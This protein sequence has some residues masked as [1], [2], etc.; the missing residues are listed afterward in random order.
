M[1]FPSGSVIRT[2][3]YTLLVKENGSL[4]C[5]R[6]GERTWRSNG[7]TNAT[8]PSWKN[9]DVFL[10]EQEPEWWQVDIS[11]PKDW[12]LPAKQAADEAV[13]RGE[14]CGHIYSARHKD[15][16]DQIVNPLVAFYRLM[17]AADEFPATYKYGT[18]GSPYSKTA[19]QLFREVE[20][21]PRKWVE[22]AYA[23][24]VPAKN[25]E[26]YLNLWYRYQQTQSPLVPRPDSVPVGPVVP[27]PPAPPAPVAPTPA[28]TAA[29][30][31]R[32]HLER[33]IKAKKLRSFLSVV[34]DPEVKRKIRVTD[35]DGEICGE[36]YS[37]SL[38]TVFATI[39]HEEGGFSGCYMPLNDFLELYTEL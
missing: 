3:T 8:M 15:F 1:N 38:D 14:P 21:D 24:G 17:K 36:A 30:I 12:F 29:D 4:R 25:R 35:T 7:I 28:P 11:Y 33:A 37:L 26:K 2:P 5:L 9:L 27:A 6:E 20:P 19:E 22:L 39:Y 16:R 32:E 23:R 18:H 34:V 13:K 31:R 10:Y